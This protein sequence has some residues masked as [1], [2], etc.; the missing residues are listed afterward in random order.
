MQLLVWRV[1]ADLWCCWSMF[2]SDSRGWR[3]PGRPRRSGWFITWQQIRNSA[4]F[5]KPAAGCRDLFCDSVKIWQLEGC[6][7]LVWSL[8]GLWVTVESAE[9]KSTD[10]S[11][12]VLFFF[13]LS[14]M[15]SQC[16]C[17]KSG[18]KKHSDDSW[19]SLS[20]ALCGGTERSEDA[21]KQNTNKS[22]TQM[23]CRCRQHNPIQKTRFTFRQQH[24]KKTDDKLQKH[25]SNSNKVEGFSHTHIQKKIKERKNN[26]N[27]SNKRTNKPNREF[28]SGSYH[29]DTLGK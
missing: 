7:L 1:G 29:R 19:V 28:S 6:E 4:S 21:N 17:W 25:A 22:Q 12:Q 13:F 24:R 11:F 8:F 3:V 23:E 26:K 10:E 18:G 27:S 16:G 5:Y 9:D 14:W 15:Y 2:S 20:A